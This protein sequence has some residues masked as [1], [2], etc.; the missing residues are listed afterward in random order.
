V[1]SSA[2]IYQQTNNTNTPTF[3]PCETSMPITSSD[4]QTQ[5]HASKEQ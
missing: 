5:Q 1:E 4:K 2:V 3:L